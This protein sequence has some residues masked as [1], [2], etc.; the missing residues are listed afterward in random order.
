MQGSWTEVCQV[1]ASRTGALQQLQH[2]CFV[3]LRLLQVLGRLGLDAQG[4]RR[5][6]TGGCE[7]A[8]MAYNSELPWRDST[9]SHMPA[10]PVR[11]LPLPL[12][13]RRG[14]W[15]QHPARSLPPPSSNP[16]HAASP[17]PAH[18]AHQLRRGPRH[19]CTST[20]RV[21]FATCQVAAGGHVLDRL[22]ARWQPSMP[23][24]TE[25]KLS[26][27]A[28]YSRLQCVALYSTPPGATS[29]YSNA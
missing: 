3:Q 24:P 14:F 16:A 15:A 28:H 18:W 8:S 22:T 25:S 29:L 19:V 9:V 27:P 26:V 6:V 1:P 2:V 10:Y 11:R 5:G 4:L 23:A 7:L 13:R 21:L 20:R 17:S 12:R